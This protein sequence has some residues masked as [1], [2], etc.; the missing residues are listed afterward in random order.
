VDLEL[1]PDRLAI[2]RLDAVDESNLQ[3][4]S[5]LFSVT[6]TADELSV[7]CPEQ[8]AP[9]A[10][11]DVSEGWRAL[12]V[13]GPLDHNETGVLASIA[14]PLADAGVSLFPLATYDTDYVLVK[15]P[16]V[17]RAAGAL[18]A[19]GHHIAPR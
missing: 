6:R 14:A 9:D 10:A 15:E 7:V 5:G 2:C 19:A 11:R 4:A 17:E 3:A 18:E 13:H 1:L 8:D 12:K 16:D